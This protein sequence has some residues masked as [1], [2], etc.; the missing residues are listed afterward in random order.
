MHNTASAPTLDLV[1]IRDR[2]RKLYAGLVYDVLEYVG[3]PNQA[4]FTRSLR[5]RRI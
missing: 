4:L 5:S 2:Y 1:E 3:Y